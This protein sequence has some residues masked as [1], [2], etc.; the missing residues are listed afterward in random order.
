M[1]SLTLVVFVLLAAGCAGPGPAAPDD[2]STPVLAR[3]GCAGCHG[4]SSGPLAGADAPL[5]GTLAIAPNLTPDRAT[6]LGGWSTAE[7]ERAVRSGVDDEGVALCGAMPRYAALPAT[8]TT[9]IVRALQALAPVAHA[10]PPSRCDDAPTDAATPVDAEVPA[11]AMDAAPAAVDATVAVPR[12]VPLDAPMA[13]T[14]DAPDASLDAPADTV[15]DAPSEDV[16]PSGCRPVINEVL[17][18]V[19]GV[20]GWAWIEVFDPCA[21]GFAMDGWRVGWRTASDPSPAGALDRATVFAFGHVVLAPGA[22]LLLG[23]PSYPGTVD[24]HFTTTLTP[25][26]GSIALRDPNGV[27]V[28]AVSWGTAAD[29]LRRGDPAPAPPRLGPP[30]ASLARLPDGARTGDDAR[31]LHVTARPTPRA[32]NR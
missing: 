14:A 16:A 4:G 27:V 26:G 29:A 2:P 21:V 8:E 12:D 3:H 25:A 6:G 11:P 19:A 9:A 24:G 13:P 18:A 1:R 30:G 17:P 28:D 31:D 5:P 32:P 7:I 10:S 15:S 22:Y 23:G 20:A